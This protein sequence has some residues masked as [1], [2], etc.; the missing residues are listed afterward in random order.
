MKASELVK[1]LEN[2]IE[3]YGDLDVK[4]E[5]YSENDVYGWFDAYQVIADIY[6]PTTPQEAEGNFLKIC[7]SPETEG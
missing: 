7:F 5:V 6:N 4:T 1:A 2:A 3:K